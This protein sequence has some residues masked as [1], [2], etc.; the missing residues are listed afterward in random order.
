MTGPAARGS[1]FGDDAE[2]YER[3]RPGYPD[4]AIDWLLPQGARD[5]LDL[6]AGTGKLTAALV[7]RGLHVI[8]VDHDDRMLQ[9]LRRRHPSVETHAAPAEALPIASGSVD[10][11][12]V[13]DAWHWFDPAA[14]AAEA[15]RVLRADGRLGLLWHEPDIEAGWAQDIARLDPN[16][17]QRYDGTRDRVRLPGVRTETRTFRWRWQVTPAHLRALL[18]TRS[19]YARLGQEERDARLD[20][21]EAVARRVADESGEPWVQWPQTTLAVRCFVR[22]AS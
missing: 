2:A 11:V 4:D 6:G 8:A 12:L 10:A 18:G 17:A 13:G 5:V 21:A 14:A 7:D 1:S 16:S 15:A 19:A 20:R 3:W 9:V 22:S